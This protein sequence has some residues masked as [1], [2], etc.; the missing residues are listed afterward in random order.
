V[1]SLMFLFLRNPLTSHIMQVFRFVI[2][3]LG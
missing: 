3:N 2:A 1:D